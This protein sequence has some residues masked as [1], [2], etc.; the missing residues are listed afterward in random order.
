MS[1]L[2]RPMADARDGARPCRYAA[3]DVG[4]ARVRSLTPGGPAI[5]DRRSAGA[6]ALVRPVRHGMVAEP[7]ACRRLVHDVLLDALPGGLWPLE[8][9]L[10]GVPVAA[11]ASDRR[12]LRTAVHEA[13]GCEV[14][15]VEE[16]LAAAVGVGVDVTDA[17]PCMVLD[18]GAGIVEAVVIRDG[19]I[20]DAVAVQLSA[21]TREGLPRHAMDSVVEMT[22]GLFRRIPAHQR[23]TARDNGLLV[24]GGGAL[25]AELLRLLRDALRMRVSVTP[26]P[27]HAT[28]RGLTRLCLQ[29]Y[30]A[31]RIGPPV[32]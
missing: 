16:P 21:T 27:A 2:Y 7:A 26:E 9:V 28:V 24:T 1:P 19:A 6:A 18:V 31:A 14:T 23:P 15:L 8:R 11:T 13:A 17:R 29:P 4:T 32:R 10:A 3:L 25:Q 30:L 22:A 5:V 12:A 20:T